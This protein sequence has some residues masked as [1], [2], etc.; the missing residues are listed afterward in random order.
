[1]SVLVVDIRRVG[2]GVGDWFVGVHMAMAPCGHH[3]MRVRMVPIVVAVRMLMLHR[4]MRMF[5]PVAFCQMQQHPR[6]HQKTT[7][8][9]QPPRRPFT[10]AERYSRTYERCKGEHGASP[11]RTKSPLRQKVEPK[12]QAI[13][14]G[15]YGKEP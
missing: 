4:L 1:M 5:M 6:Q 11:R 9:H 10:E 14:R 2:M 12:T 15:P 3:V 8:Q 7:E 13:P